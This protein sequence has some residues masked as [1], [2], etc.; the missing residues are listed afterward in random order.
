MHVRQRSHHWR[1]VRQ[2]QDGL[3]GPRL[4]AAGTFTGGAIRQR[5]RVPDRGTRQTG[6]KGLQWFDWCGERRIASITFDGV[7]TRGIL[8]ELSQAGL[9]STFFIRPASSSDP[10]A[11]DTCTLV[12]RLIAEG[13]SLQMGGHHGIGLG[14]LDAERI[15]QELRDG[16]DWVQACT[17]R[18]IYDLRVN[19]I[20]VVGDLDNG[21]ARY[22]AD[23]GYVIA[24]YN[25]DAARSVPVGTQFANLPPGSSALVRFNVPSYEIGQATALAAEIRSQ[26]YGLV[27][28]QTCYKRCTGGSGYCKSPL[29]DSGVFQ[30]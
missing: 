20:R 11:P 23:K 21:R 15:D 29:A 28:S 6:K 7:P 4:H 12:Q 24:S 1:P 26:H 16:E 19:Q 17:G 3:G 14:S 30:S 8:D 27:T 5:W 22:I 13:H 10:P 2:V 25:V 18:S 9:R